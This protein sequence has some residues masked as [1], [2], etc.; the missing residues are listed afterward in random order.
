MAPKITT[1]TWSASSP[2][3]RPRSPRRAPP[4]GFP[5]DLSPAP[6]PTPTSTSPTSSKTSTRESSRGSRPGTPPPPTQMRNNDCA[7]TW[8]S[9]P[10]STSGSGSPRNRSPRAPPERHPTSSPC[11]PSSNAAPAQSP[12]SP[13]KTLGPPQARARRISRIAAKTRR[14]FLRGK[15]RAPTTTTTGAR[16]SGPW[17]PPGSSSRWASSS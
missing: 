16:W 11:S 17:A 9:P 14:I 8:Q 13:S 5:P 6:T 3:G 4:P 7:T 12:T 2:A 15:F 10:A 1:T